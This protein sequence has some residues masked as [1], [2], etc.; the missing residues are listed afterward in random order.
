MHFVTKNLPKFRQVF[1]V[2]CH[3]QKP[4]VFKNNETLIANLTIKQSNDGFSNISRK[5]E[6]S[7]G[8]VILK[9]DDN[10][11]VSSLLEK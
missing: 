2:T 5:E 6:L 9:E 8:S 4:N 11:Q 3:S 10:Q 1:F 7:T